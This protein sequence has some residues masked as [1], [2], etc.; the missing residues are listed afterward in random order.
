MQTLNLVENSNVDFNAFK[1]FDTRD[2][3]DNY[4][5][6]ALTEQLQTSLDLKSLLNIFAMEASKYIN[7]SGLYFKQENISAAARGSK[8]GK[9]ERL[10]ELKINNEY[11]GTLT[12]ALNSPISLTNNKILKELHQLLIHPINNAIKYQQ[13]M[14]LA[15]QD[16]LTGLGNRRYFD[17]QLKRA[18]HH[19]NRQRS[20]VGL[21]VCDLNKFKVINDNYGHHVGDEILVNFAQALIHSVRDS[22]S[23]FRFGGDEFVIIVEDASEQSLL[24]IEERISHALTTNSLLAKYHVACALGFT[25]MNRADDPTSFF[26]RA[27]SMLYRDKVASHKALSLI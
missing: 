8:P 3:E 7:F 2:H 17:E 27:D 20:K 23:I 6:L 5:K 19:A 16:G 18:M 15:M 26:E 13:A 1:L 9:K 14:K 10:F 11:I 4:R 25:F 22:D 24:I 21:M 12:Y